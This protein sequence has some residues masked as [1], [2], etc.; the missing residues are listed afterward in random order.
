[1]II[2][3]L[4]VMAC[5]TGLESIAQQRQNEIKPDQYRAIHWGMEDGL[6]WYFANLMIK[7]A[8]GFMWFGTQWGG[9]CRFDGAVFEKMIFDKNK[10]NAINSEGIMGFVEDSLHNIWIG[11]KYELSRYDIRADTFTNFVKAND[12]IHYK[13]P[14]VPFWSTRDFVYCLETDQSIVSYNIHSFQK[15]VLLTLTDT[16]NSQV[17]GL[18]LNYAI[19]DEASNCLWMLELYDQKEDRGGLLRVSLD[20]GKRQRYTWPFYSN[21]TSH[22]HSALGMRLDRKRNSI[23]LNSSDGLLEFSLDDRQFHYID[24]LNEFVKLKDYDRNLGIDIDQG[25]RIWLT[26][27]PTGVLIYDPETNFAKQL[28]SDPD[29]LKKTGV[30][31]DHI[32]CDRD[33]IVWTSYWGGVSGISEFLPFN[34]P[35]KRYAG[36]PK[37]SDSLSSGI[38]YTI[39]PA[40][41]GKLW[42]GTRDGLNIFDP[43]TEK[44]EVLRENDLPG[45][46]GTV[47]VPLYIDTIRQKAWLNAGL[48]EA[49]FESKTYEMD[50]RTRICRPIVFRDQSKQIVTSSNLYSNFFPYNDGIML[51]DENFGLFEMKWDSLY[52]D[53][54]IP[55]KGAVGGGVVEEDQFMFFQR[56]G[57]EPNFTFENKN[58]KWTRVPT[59]SIA[60]IGLPCYITRRIK[61]TG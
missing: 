23:W 59:C 39:I 48:N 55:F 38:I 43:A 36:N 34:P 60:W 46:R 24:A 45:I 30:G 16:E 50:I 21:N 27:T 14:A 32:Y 61:R 5:L 35:V 20:D 18:G 26:T 19:L 44:F 53:L 41:K 25:G 40:D 22:R 52:A 28:F 47:I 9:L 10:R 37:N 54:L 56:G 11:T 17:G 3:I 33:G 4:F 6:G 49:G 7:D 51:V 42:I 12:S 2:P 15:K 29:L 57:D 58:G 13:R 8:K 31:N 1:M